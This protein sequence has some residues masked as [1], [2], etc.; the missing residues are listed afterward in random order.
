[1][2]QLINLPSFPFLHALLTKKGVF[3]DLPNFQGTKAFPIIQ[4][5]NGPQLTSPNLRIIAFGEF[6][7][8][9]NILP[10]G[11]GPKT[12]ASK[13]HWQNIF[14]TKLDYGILALS[15]E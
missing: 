14:Y 3:W 15:I 5:L 1:M 13:P 7:T 10:R 11:V 9:S 2:D 12:K 6:Y 4:G 8:Q